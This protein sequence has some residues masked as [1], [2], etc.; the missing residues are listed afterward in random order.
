MMARKESHCRN[1]KK[2]A[3]N[4]AIEARHFHQIGVQEKH[5]T[6]TMGWF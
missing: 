5:H 2:I 1:I 3:T 4:A 6:Y